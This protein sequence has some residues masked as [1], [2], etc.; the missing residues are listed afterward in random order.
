[1]E[2]LKSGKTQTH[3]C[4]S[5]IHPDT[6]LPAK[7][8]DLHTSSE[9]AA[10]IIETADEI[11][12]LAQGNKDTQVNGTNTMFFI[13]KSDIPAGRKPTYLR[14]VAAD[15][16]N[17]E[18]TKRIHFTVGGDRIDYPGDVSTKTAQ[19]TTAKLLLNSIISTNGA[20]LLVVDRKDFYLNT[21]ME[22]YKYMAIHMADI[23]Q[24][25]HSP[26]PGSQWGC[27]C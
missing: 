21:P 19:L 24:L 15:R 23:N 10:W 9:G 20:H 27:V 2:L 18:R 5:A 14:I 7:Y 6:R 11:G 4:F 8:Q 12:C 26:R 16:P 17:K 13:R 1:M 25:I 22:C 3:Y